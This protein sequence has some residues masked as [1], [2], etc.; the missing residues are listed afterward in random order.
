MALGQ[1]Q[2][3]GKGV[4]IGYLSTALMG[5]LGGTALMWSHGALEAALAAPIGGSLSV[6]LAAAWTMSRS[7]AST[8]S[9][10]SKRKVAAHFTPVWTAAARLA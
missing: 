3:E 9:R 1:Q 4:I 10:Q 2:P 7:S 6:I 5:T 8:F